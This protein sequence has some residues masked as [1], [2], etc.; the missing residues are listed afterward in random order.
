[1]QKL[2]KK[3]LKG[4]QTIKL[5][6]ITLMLVNLMQGSAVWLE[7]MSV[8]VDS[9]KLHFHFYTWTPPLLLAHETWFWHQSNWHPVFRHKILKCT[10][11]YSCPMGKCLK[12]QKGVTTSVLT[13]R[14]LFVNLGATASGSSLGVHTYVILGW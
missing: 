2:K 12:R 11:F 9:E 6:S 13:T 8:V 3:I 7:C 10:H 14:D 5:H 4:S 1:M